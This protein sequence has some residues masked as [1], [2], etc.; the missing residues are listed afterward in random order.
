ML[1]PLADRPAHYQIQWLDALFGRSVSK[2]ERKG[3]GIQ[4][5]ASGQFR[6]RSLVR[7]LLSP[8]TWKLADN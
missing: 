3:V 1:L 7:F 8:M 2:L 6:S 5:A 4:C